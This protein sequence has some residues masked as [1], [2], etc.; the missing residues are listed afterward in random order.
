VIAPALSAESPT[1]SPFTPGELDRYAEVAV[2]RC[3]DLRQGER[4]LIE[5]EPEHRPLAVALHRAGYRRGLRVAS[6]VRDP[7]L[8][9]AELDHASEH[10]LG[11][12]EPWERD[13]SLARTAEDSALICIKGDELPGVLDGVDPHRAGLRTRRATRAI[14]ELYE[15]VRQHRD[16]FVI[17]AYPTL[18]WSSRVF[19]ELTPTQASRALAEDLLTFSRIG[20]H[21]PA[22]ALDRHIATLRERARIANGLELRRL[23]FRGPGTDLTIG[24][25]DDHLW[26]T[27]E[28][29]NAFGR[30]IFR[31]LPS[32][33]IFTAPAASVTEGVVSCTKPLSTK[34]ILCEDIRIEFRSGRLVRLDA[35]SEAQRDTLLAQ[36]DVDEGGRR[37]GEVA[38]VDSGSRVG[39]TGRLY[40]NTLLDE[41]QACHLGLGLGFP[42][43]RRQGGASP[44]LNSSR[45]HVDVMIGGPG[46]DVTGVTASG[47]TIPLIVDGTWR[48]D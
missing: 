34:G 7:L 17:V 8:A 12:V 28:F 35:R 2:E 33:E 3:L 46:V 48:P 23:C 37:L 20:A 13:W 9:R 44:D 1:G 29:T 15:R 43:C 36:L 24:L 26:R 45:T 39:S 27:A 5:Y 42:D 10:L 30:T 32:E 16:S 40:W 6:Q 4:L 41:N 22:G 11:S 18:A 31:N 14:A 47:R 38:L 19:P 21:D 25:P